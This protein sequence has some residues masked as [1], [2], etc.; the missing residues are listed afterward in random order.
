M[1]S[2]NQG[3]DSG[4]YTLPASTN[5]DTA[6]ARATLSPK[7]FTGRT[8]NR[9]SALSAWISDWPLAASSMSTAFGRQSSASAVAWRVSSGNSARCRQQCNKQ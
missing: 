6:D 2:V 5:G 1:K 7:G 8:G 9:V 4:K 3:A